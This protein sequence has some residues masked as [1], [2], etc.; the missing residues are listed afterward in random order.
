MTGLCLDIGS[1]PWPKQDYEAV[2]P[3]EPDARVDFRCNM[4][5]LP[6]S[7]GS[8]EAI[9]SSHALEHVPK[10]KVV[11]TLAE[12]HRVL[13]PGGLLQLEVPDLLWVCRNFLEHPVADWNMDT[14]FGAQTR[15]GEYHQTGFTIEIL[16]DYLVATGFTLAEP[17]S[18][19]FNHGQDTLHAE[20][21]K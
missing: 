12:W 20:A 5:D 19:V 15:D 14:I 6:Y 13:Q 18:V 16:G 10:A 11:P 21:R 4:W 17:I 2:D 3:Y 8:V 1:G 9:W 7:D